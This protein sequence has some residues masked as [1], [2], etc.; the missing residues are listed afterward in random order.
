MAVIKS[1]DT[2]ERLKQRKVLAANSLNRT[3]QIRHNGNS[4][5][6]LLPRAEA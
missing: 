3:A 2:R 5:Q 6:L 1:W 4:N